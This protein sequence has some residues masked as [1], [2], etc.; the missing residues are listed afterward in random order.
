MKP[1]STGKLRAL[2]I[3]GLVCANALV[4][5]LSAQSLYQSRELYILRA[6]ATT[7][8]IS[9]ALAQNISGSI[10]KIDLTLHTVADELE[11]QLAGKGLDEG[12]MN[13]FLTRQADRL[14]EIVAIRVSNADGLVI[15]GAQGNGGARVSWADQEYFRFHRD[16]AKDMLRFS[17][18]FIGP[19]SKKYIVAFSRRYNTPDGR[20]AGVV[21]API[22]VEHFAKLL[23]RY[24]L[25]PHGSAILRDADLGLI[26]RHPPLP[27]KAAGQVGN[28][29]VSGIGRQLSQALKDAVSYHA[30]SGSDGL[31]RVYTLR[32]LPNAPILIGTSVARS[33]YLAPWDREMR[34]TGGMALGF[35]LLS[36][37]TGWL[38]LR[39]YNMVKEQQ[40][41]LRQSEERL[42]AITDNANAVIFL[43][44]VQGR[45]L[46]VNRY[47]E[48]LFHITNAE[49]AGKTDYDVFPHDMASAFTKNDQTVLS[50]G[51]PLEVEELVPQDGGV[52]TYLSV[53]FPLQNSEGGIYAVCGIAT[54]ISERKK[55]EAERLAL[56]TKLRDSIDAYHSMLATTLDGFWELDRSGRLTNVNDTYCR[57]SGYTHE[58]LIGM[59]ISDI[60]AIESAAD[61]E[62]HNRRIKERGSDQFESKHR[63][64][65]GSIWEVEVSASYSPSKGGQYFGFLRDITERKR[66]ENALKLSE[67]KFRKAFEVSP[68]A[69]N[70]NR[71]D[72]GEY[73]SINSG[74]TRILGYTAAEIV[75]RTSLELNIWVDPGDRTRLV[76]ILKREGM[77]SNLEARFRAK[78]GS[79]RTGLRSAALI[80]IDGVAHIIGV[81]RDI[82]ERKHAEDARVK[83]ETQLRESQKMEALGTLAG[84]VAHDFNNIVAAILGNVELAR[85][86]AEPGH[87]VLESLSEIR[88]ASLRAKAL[89]QQILSFSRRQVIERKI[90]T[91]EP[92][93]H[94]SERLLRATLPAG[95]R[96]STHCATETPE[97]LADATQIEQVLIN[98]CTNA[99]QSVQS[100]GR[101]GSIE[102]ALEAR[103]CGADAVRD[104]GF[105]LVSGEMPPGRYAC[106]SVK[107][108]GAGMAEDTLTRIFEPFFTTKPVG[109]G[110][111]LG[112]AVVHGIVEEHSGSIEVRS[113]LGVG[114]TFRIYLPAAQTADKAEHA[115][116]PLPAAAPGAGKRVLYL[117]DDES[118]VFLMTRLLE[119]QGYRVSGYTDAHAAIAAVRAQ[120]QDYSLAITDYNMPEL[121]G[122]DV[123]H[124]LR[125]I[126]P[127]LPLAMASGY[128]TEELRQQAADTGISDL[129]YKPN[130]VDELCT[131]VA[132]LVQA[133]AG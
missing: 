36:L 127:D 59:H 73:V 44:D 39:Q 97:V 3:G 87:A 8:N 98:L 74:F 42:R 17:K 34:R 108:N 41:Q 16:H 18:P 118:I 94:E 121:T 4:L 55:E 131:A 62:E 81:T 130:T 86:D 63:R 1:F 51:R 22:D 46:H 28:N 125:A 15:L 19:I 105:A 83:L 49:L 132:R 33:D 88:K 5:T 104:E 85:Q 43:K 31:E 53:R 56:Q 37:T 95:V 124:A 27:D 102:I 64:K 69:I 92:V 90:I 119:R 40:Q 82:T 72:D 7:T 30:P 116:V 57:Q 75:G 107:D 71:L 122:I 99:W 35:L 106:L 103:Q 129:I 52:H 109:K 67:E 70:I 60:E 112:L 25:G 113:I 117:D 54:D 101:P 32:R 2:L 13:A 50:S 29:E 61:A 21:L 14:D 66:A 10:E 11:R 78:D 68:D 24:D 110:T 91:L 89:V 120:P 133:T 6:E 12:A 114:S 45:Y 65:D 128:I 23:A 47:Y 38:L 9:A 111:G 77:V 115:D 96:L 79:I 76:E 58:E 20:F 100:L 26:A 48:Q 123:A 126:R 84:G 93:L 80:D